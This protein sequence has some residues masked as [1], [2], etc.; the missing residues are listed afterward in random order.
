M[1]EKMFEVAITDHH[2]THTMMSY[3]T[4]FAE[5]F[6]TRSIKYTAK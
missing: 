4:T 5:H 3:G 2:S 6:A 1:H